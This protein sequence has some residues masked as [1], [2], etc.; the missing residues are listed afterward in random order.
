MEGGNRKKSFLPGR[1]VAKTAETH[2]LP[3]LTSL[4][5]SST[6]CKEIE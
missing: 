1:T 2:A 5:F 3:L 4:I 6:L